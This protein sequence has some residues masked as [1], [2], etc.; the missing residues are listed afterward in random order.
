MYSF[1]EIP[2][3]CVSLVKC[4]VGLNESSPNNSTPD[5]RHPVMIPH[6]R[7]LLITPVLPSLKSFSIHGSLNLPCPLEEFSGLVEVAQF[8]W[9]ILYIVENNVG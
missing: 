7:L 6:L 3:R 8:Y 1:N 4:E 2:R 9:L 5:V